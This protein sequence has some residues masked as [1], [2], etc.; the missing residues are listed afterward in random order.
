MPP[1]DTEI[2]P[3]V[4]VGVSGIASPIGLPHSPRGK[5]PSLLLVVD[6][7][8]R[9]GAAELRQALSVGPR[10]PRGRRSLHGVVEIKHLACPA[11]S[12]HLRPRR[13]T[14]VLVSINC[15]H[16]MHSLLNAIRHPAS[17]FMM[18][19]R[20]P[21]LQLHVQK[22][23]LSAW[24]IQPLRCRCRNSPRG[25]WLQRPAANGA[26]NGQDNVQS[27]G[28]RPRTRMTP[29]RYV[30]QTSPIWVKPS[31]LNLKQKLS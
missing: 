10:G 19:K 5:L 1:R 18:R 31:R 12:F 24:R 16:D 26:P 30:D 15:T 4:C 28:S 23:K 11:E 6:G 8:R 27:I 29:E 9:E 3:S 20:L 17:V 22:S 2:V 21:G 14:V 25:G 7:G 13:E